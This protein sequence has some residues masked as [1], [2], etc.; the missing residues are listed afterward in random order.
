MN[1]NI[2]S[3]GSHGNAVVIE[4]SILIDLGVS[5]RLLNDVYKHLKI[6]L[7]THI[8]SDHFNKAAI[9]RLAIERPTLR[10]GCPKW[11]VKPLVNLGVSKVNIDILVADETYNYKFCKIIPFNLYHNVQNC[12]YKLHFSNGKV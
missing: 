12:G 1:Y 2:I 8:H 5:F 10:W 6:V 3:T 7:L 9:R 4:R 11:L